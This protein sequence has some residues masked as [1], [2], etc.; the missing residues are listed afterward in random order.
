LA[1]YK[2]DDARWISDMTARMN[3][4]AI[5]EK[6]CRDAINKPWIR[7]KT[8]PDYSPPRWQDMGLEPEAPL[9]K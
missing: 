4:H 6:K 9:R 7:L 8:D 5:M 2:T 3:Y 1:D